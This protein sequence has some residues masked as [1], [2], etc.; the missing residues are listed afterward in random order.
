MFEQVPRAGKAS[1][2][3]LLEKVGSWFENQVLNDEVFA[4]HFGVTRSWWS[5]RTAALNGAT[6]ASVAIIGNIGDRV[7]VRSAFRQRVPAKIPLL[8]CRRLS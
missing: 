5:V 6:L 4:A 2:G 7:T 8:P 1:A 3:I